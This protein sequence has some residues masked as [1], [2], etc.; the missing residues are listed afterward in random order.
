M[1]RRFGRRPRTTSRDAAIDAS[2]W[3]TRIV[4]AGVVKA[5]T[6][7]PVQVAGVPG[8]LAAVG[9]GE[10][11]DGKPL[12]VGFAPRVGGDAVLASLAR[13]TERAAGAGFEDGRAVAIA[14]VWSLAARRI[15]GIVA[16]P[17]FG[18]QALA[19]PG[20]ADSGDGVE[21]LAIEPPRVVSIAQLAAHPARVE[22]RELFARAADGIAG[23]AA[24]HGGAVCGVGRSLEL[25][26]M[27]RRMAV[28]R[29]DEA[30]VVLEQFLPGRSTERVDAESLSEVLD[31]LEGSLRKRL[32]DRKVRDSEEGM[33]ARLIPRLAASAELRSLVRWPAGG[34]DLAPIDFVALDAAGHPLAGVVRQ[35]LGLEG[36]GPILDGVLG[37]A[38]ALP[39]LLADA[40][41]PVRIEAPR[42]LLA[43]ERIE[44]AAARVLAAL[45]LS[46]ER[47][48]TTSLDLKSASL[49][50]GSPE[51]AEIAPERAREGRGSADGR[52]GR[53][54]ERGRPR[55]RGRR[56]GGAEASDER[57]EA[58]ASP[59]PRRF[60]ELSPFDLQDEPETEVGDGGNNE[61]RGRG[62]SRRGRRGRPSGERGADADVRPDAKAEPGEGA[63]R[64][65]RRGGRRG[66]SQRPEPR[67]DRTE[68]DR[69]EPDELE[70]DVSPDFDE[71][72]ADGIVPLSP[73][74]PELAAKPAPSYEEDEEAE[75]G[76]AVEETTPAPEPD[77]DEP[78]PRARPRRAGILV[79]ADRDSI[80]AG[81]LLAREARQLEGLWV[82][83]Q[84]ELMTFFRSVAIDLPE[85]AQIFVVGF[86]ASP[87]RDAIQAAAL[88]NGRIDWFD[89]QS[90]PPEDLQQL[91]E[92]IG[93]D[94]VHVE[95]RV[96][97]VLPTVLAECSRRSRFSDKLVEL[98]TG[99]FSEHDFSRWGRLWWSRLGEMAEMHGDRRADIDLLLGGRPSDLTREAERVPAPPPPPEF[100]DSAERDFRLVHFGGYILVLV[101]TPAHLNPHMEARIVR[102]RHAAQLSLAWNEGSEVVHLGGD[103]SS[104][105]HGLDLVGMVNHLANK[106]TW[107]EALPNVDR[108]ARFR[109]R[110]LPDHPERIDVVVSEIAMGRSIF[111]G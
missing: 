79:H 80:A 85:D 29:A 97:T 44:D 47:V 70:N 26:L 92:A 103:E 62:R 98:M 53:G 111:E 35:E 59:S 45:N 74:A 94:R 38:S 83:P 69:A 77:L 13:A 17:E 31:R 40:R 56:Q 110:D 28:L 99:R 87:A 9:E 22:D 64:S 11:E 60:E 50:R 41:P 36:L 27:A 105:R 86:T 95:A 5:R 72:L 39:V 37:L 107:V 18:W 78:T 16:P 33:R 49:S 42:L 52:R 75:G 73:G 63:Q 23:L 10:D 1:R 61:R 14:P 90:W 20:L 102:E 68:P 104:A 67:S 12:V 101:P 88:Y 84:S 48:D 3:L 82:Y 30:G 65:G 54:R 46:V 91:A 58:P 108:A 81:I 109:V 55:D 66:A 106:H 96:D 89:H 6:L 71:D 93:E 7:K 51:L 43:T 2:H 4:E 57:A 100:A 34:S 76:D 32:N 25:M 8:S 24:K 15:L 19:A 21:P